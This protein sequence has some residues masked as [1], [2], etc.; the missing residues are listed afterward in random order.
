VVVAVPVAAVGAV[1]VAG[2]AAAVEV[3]VAEHRLLRD[4]RARTRIN[5]TAK[6]G[7]GLSLAAS[8]PPQFVVH[9]FRTIRGHLRRA[10]TIP[11]SF[12]SN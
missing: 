10:E 5:N 8:I 11:V 12:V 7:Q 6:H 9:H 4:P 1:V 2:A 3:P